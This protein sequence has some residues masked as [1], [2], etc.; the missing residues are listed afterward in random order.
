M[1]PGSRFANTAGPILLFACLWIE[2]C[3]LFAG[4]SQEAPEPAIDLVW[5]N[6]PESPRI[7]YLRSV[8]TP[9]DLG[10]TKSIWRR[11]WEFI[12]GEVE[13]KIVKPYGIQ[14]DGAGKIYIADSVERFIHVFDLEGKGYSKIG[15]PQKLK[16]PID[17][18]IDPSGE[19]YV[20]DAELGRVFRYDSSGR[21][22]GEIGLE[23]NLRRPA[24]IVYNLVNGLLY[25]VDVSQHE[26]LAYEPSGK[27]RFKFGRRGTGNG[28][29]NFP[30]NITVDKRGYLYVTDSLNFRIQIFDPQGNFVSLFGRPGDALGEFSKPKGIALDSEGHIYVV[31]GLYDTI[32]IFD[33]GGRL[34][35]TFGSPG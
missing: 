5:P 16:F 21:P 25:V 19:I 20:S 12:A 7:R 14:T 32:I 3:A 10:I 8:A 1:K 18:A 31:E 13:E 26:V 23:G 17:L 35:L 28:E 9:K 33:Q 24:G 4:N 2:G 29:F 15:D 11:I 30:T 6:P 34:L 27:L 22:T